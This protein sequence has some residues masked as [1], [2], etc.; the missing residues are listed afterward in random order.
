MKLLF[1]LII[2]LT[3]YLWFCLT[4]SAHGSGP[5]YILINDEYVKA[6]P[7]AEYVVPSQFS[8]GADVAPVSRYLVNTPI[9]FAVDDEFIPGEKD[10]ELR[11]NLGDGSELASGSAVSHIYVKPGTYLV[12]LH[13]KSAT[14]SDQF[15]PVNTIQINLVPALDYKLPIAKIVVNDKLINDPV[16]DLIELNPFAQ[17]VFDGQK[18]TGI[19]LKYKWDLGDDSGSQENKLKHRYKLNEPFPVYPVLR[20]TD[21]NGIFSDAYAVMDMRPAVSG[22]WE[23]LW[24]TIIEFWGR[25]W[26]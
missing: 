8:V 15:L 20:V 9:S 19:N 1:N 26:P 10:S 6:N 14:K 11:W 2:S 21:G 24:L 18:S 17:L 4:V 7:I 3:V 16:R 22:V 12:E 23:Q 13:I 25:W 5:Q